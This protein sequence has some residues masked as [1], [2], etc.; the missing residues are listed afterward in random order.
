M[1]ANDEALYWMK[2]DSWSRVDRERDC[3]EL[4]SEAPQ[5]AIDSF[6]LYLLRNDLPVEEGV[7]PGNAMGRRDSSVI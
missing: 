4:T 6:R 2:N 7:I 3:L 5:R 1:R